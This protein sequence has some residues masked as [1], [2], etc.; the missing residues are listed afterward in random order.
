MDSLPSSP[1]LPNLRELGGW[2][3]AGGK[4][5]ASGILFRSAAPIDPRVRTDPAVTNLGLEFVVD[6]RTAS[7]A[8]GK[9]DILP[10]NAHLRSIDILGGAPGSAAA[11]PGQPTEEMAKMIASLTLDAAHEKM[12]ETYRDLVS[13]DVAS[14][15]YA[16]LIRIVLEAEG[17]PVLYHCTAGKDR[18]GWAT[19]ILMS[20]AGVPYDSVLAEYL[21][22]N[23]AVRALF[24]PLAARFLSAGLSP[25][26]A[27]E[28]ISVQK[29]YLDTAF[30]EVD[31]HFGGFEGYLRDGLGLDASELADPR[32]LLTR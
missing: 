3:V 28:L 5:F 19:A 27:D 22:V 14:A 7:E 13:N 24:E 2:T 16:S 25:E 9:P 10:P 21:S 17:A 8:E 11:I 1:S 6:L 30:A 23:P 29:S 4:T 18:T 31:A 26:I 15:G 20:A 12:M 32:N